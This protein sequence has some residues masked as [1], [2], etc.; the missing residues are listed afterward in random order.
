MAKTDEAE[1]IIR[2]RR[3]CFF[4]LDVCDVMEKHMKETDRKEGP[5]TRIEAVTALTKMAAG[6]LERHT[7]A[8]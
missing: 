7:G 6:E 3:I 5:L 2:E 8:F 1:D 4:I